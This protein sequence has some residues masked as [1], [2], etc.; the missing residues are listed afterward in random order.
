MEIFRWEQRWDLPCTSQGRSV[1]LASSPTSI[2]ALQQLLGS[3]ADLMPGLKQSAQSTARGYCISDVPD[4][5][6]PRSGR[7]QKQTKEMPAL[8]RY[9]DGES[10]ILLRMKRVEKVRV[11]RSFQMF[12]M[13]MSCPLPLMRQWSE[14]R[15]KEKKG[16]DIT[17]LKGG[18]NKDKRLKAIIKACCSALC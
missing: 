8:P 17:D 10:K 13:V 12:Q 3:A 11:H 18:I 1:A 4:P 6:P 15:V 14:K 9:C 2:A 5:A 7:V 16:N